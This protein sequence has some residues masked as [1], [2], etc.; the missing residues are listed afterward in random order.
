MADQETPQRPEQTF[1]IGGL[2]AVVWHNT[3]QTEEGTVRRRSVQ[4]EKRYKASTG[5]F[6]STNSFSPSELGAVLAVVKSA[7]DYCMARE[8]EDI[9]D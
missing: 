1:R 8:S 4:V 2:R 5:E 9:A 3:V 6:K 7:L